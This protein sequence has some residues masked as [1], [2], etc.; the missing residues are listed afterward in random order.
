MIKTRNLVFV[1]LAT[2]LFAAHA[3]AAPYVAP[4]GA[5]DRNTI[6]FAGN[7]SQI[8]LRTALLPYQAPSGAEADGSSW[9]M[10]TAVNDSIRPATRIL[11]AGQPADG[12]LHFFPLPARPSIRQVA[13]SD[14]GVTVE[15]AP[16][17]GRSSYRVTIPPATSVALA[18]RVANGKASPSVLAWAEPALVAHNRKFAIFVAAIA[19]L[20]AA[21]FV[22]AA[23]L[24]V[25]TGHAAP[26]WAAITLGLL[27]LTRLISTGM[28]D[29]NWITA[30]GGPYGLFALAAGL[31][32][33][34]G[35][36][37]AD[38]IIPMESM[39]PGATK[40]LRWVIIG[41]ITLAI[42][43]FIGVPGATLLTD[44][45]VVVCTAGIA[46]YLVHR[47]RLG[48]QA[49]RVVSP[50][51]AVFALVALVSA[52]AAMGA[53]SDNP[54]APA[55]AGGFAAAGA[56]LL[57]LAVAAGEGVAIVPAVRPKSKPAGLAERSAS[58]ARTS[59]VATQPS[60]SMSLPAA[61]QA[62]G[63]SHQ[64]V[65]E[66]DFTKDVVRLSHEA[67]GLIGHNGNE[68]VLP[69]KVWIARIHDED[70][71]T[72]NQALGDYRGHAGLAFRIEF[73]VKSESGRYP[74]FELRATMMGTKQQ[75]T[76][77]LGLI[78]DV[79][80]R[81]ESEAASADRSLRDTLTGLGNR[82]ALIEDLEQLVDGL[83]AT[84][85]AMLDIDRFKSIHSSLGDDGG[86]QV[87]TG[88]AERLRKRFSNVAEIYR[89][90]GDSFAM[91][92]AKGGGDPEAIGNELIELCKAPL[93]I[94]GRNVFALASVG[95]TVGSEVE[96]PLTLLRNAELAL[97]QAKRHGG[98]CARIYSHELQALAPGDA[99]A[100]ESDLRRALECGQL[101]VFYQPIMRL[102]DK[103]VAGFEALLRW[104]HP[105]KG[106]VEPGEF[107]GHSEETGLI[108]ELGRFALERAV[109]DLA[110][111]QK[112][113]PLQEPLFVSVNFSRRQLHDPDFEGF[114]QELLTRSEIP[115][116]TLKLEVTESAVQT[117]GDVLRTLTRIRALGP[118]LAID[119][120]GT[121]VS[122]LSQLKDLPFDTVKIDKA[123]LGGNA[124]QGGSAIV[125]KKIIS[126]AHE[127][128]RA[129]VVEGVEAERDVVWLSELKCEFA[130]GF[131]FS[132][133]LPAVDA[134][135]FIAMCHR[136]SKSAVHS[137]G[138]MPPSESGTP[139]VS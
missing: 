97:M 87:L 65:F 42:F 44:I 5:R 113:F 123:F 8:E 79:T 32:L 96:D 29:A 137:E 122:S 130:Q 92:F 53:F 71:E 104:N 78:A 41:L 105:T 6:N 52:L 55:I 74:W 19:G 119:D 109:L 72:Y 40:Y 37:L 110:Y 11:I 76:R 112:F 14:A 88:L 69:H 125:M 127:L 33:A 111:W 9:F 38:T 135:N 101:D 25:M 128:N 58:I 61:L 62:I 80:T 56:V 27:F 126:L 48:A 45:A 89:V 50:S 132:E 2:L 139:S 136:N 17:Y 47:G 12:G 24:A 67:A 46:L 98:S 3:M 63:A 90:G 36:K 100:L 91:L 133:P 81:K 134:L 84:T 1:V 106:L 66:L 18:I 75:A 57:A 10:M 118:G 102:E 107:V 31:S 86:D 82:I 28:F 114:L 83:S 73:R 60:P 85:F 43:A 7:I 51:A 59:E 22:I 131:Y 30:V 95:I 39:W 116:A 93:L 117:D 77:C 94:D 54:M 103:S 124:E 49:A 115:P 64:G 13:S 108:V 70:R 68:M 26:R 121:G 4:K 15:R 23:G 99:V 34:A 138:G 21:A 20:I 120:F 16:A 129:V 35:I